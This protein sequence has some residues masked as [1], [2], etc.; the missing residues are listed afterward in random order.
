MEYF[1]AI[2]RNKLLI[3]TTTW[4]D[5]KGIM[6]SEKKGHMLY[7]SNNIFILKWQNYTDGKQISGYQELGAVGAMTIKGYQDGNLWSNG[8]FC[9]FTATV[10]TQIYMW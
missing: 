5:F 8:V 1:S 10:V 6:L 9:I 3:Y 2:K 7:D 4:T